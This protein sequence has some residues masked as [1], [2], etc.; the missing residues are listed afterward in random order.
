MPDFKD[1]I[2]FLDM[3]TST[4]GLNHVN[5]K[6]SEYDRLIEAAVATDAADEEKRWSDLLEA[7]HV[8]LGKDYVVAP[9]YQQQTALLQ[10]KTISGVVKHSF[11]SPYSFKY[12][13]V[14]KAE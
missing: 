11:G 2:T 1:A 3:F 13:R 4:S 14:N 10:K 9:I 12:I 8:L 5:Y 6:S 7:E